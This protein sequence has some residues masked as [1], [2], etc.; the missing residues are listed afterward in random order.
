MSPA[1]LHELDLLRCHV[2]SVARPRATQRPH[3]TN[4]DGN[5]SATESSRNDRVG[6]LGR[7]TSSP[8]R[9]V[10]RSGTAPPSHPL[11]HP[12]V[13]SRPHFCSRRESLTH[14]TRNHPLG[15]LDHARRDPW[16][17]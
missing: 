16:T 14:A 5:L 2:H 11:H 12:R 15:R 13:G 1:L 3:P 10:R 8:L 9:S 17:P 4:G 7:T 6:G